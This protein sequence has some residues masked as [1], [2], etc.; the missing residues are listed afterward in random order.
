M[1]FDYT[2]DKA[3]M[4]SVLLNFHEQIDVAKKLTENISADGSFDHIFVFGMGG[5]ALPGNLLKCYMNDSKIPVSVFK[6][7]NIP[8]YV[9]DKSLVFV[10]SYSGNTEETINAYREV[11]K[12]GAEIM[13]IS[14]GGKL[15][16]IAKMNND[17][18]L[19]VPKNIEPRQAIGY[20]FFP[21]LFILENS[22]IIESTAKD[23]ENTKSVLKK[24]LYEKKSQEIAVKLQH[25][26]PI[27]YSSDSMSIVAEKWKI[28][29]NENAK[30]PAFYNTFPELNHNEMNG[31]LNIFG[32]YYV[33]IIKD[34]DDNPRI[35]KRMDITKD[36]IKSKGIEV[37]ELVIKGDSKLTKIFSSIHLSDWVAYHLALLYEIDPTPVDMVEDFKKK[38][39][40]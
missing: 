8:K 35:K 26:I 25:K 39:N 4:R 24:E 2:L 33:I 15:K 27:I 13:T 19:T 17:I 16:E 30:T 3:D 22:G 14:S 20:Q 28:T 23:V 34:E 10:I 11:M 40:E 1:E 38:L 5:S 7:Y 31:Y 9:N 36:L 37:M 18:H 29:L 12:T 21:I 6:N 32:D